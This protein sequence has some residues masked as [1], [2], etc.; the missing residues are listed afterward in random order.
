MAWRQFHPLVFIIVLL[1]PGRSFGWRLGSPLPVMLELRDRGDVR[2][3]WDWLLPSISRD[4]V[5]LTVRLRRDLDPRLEAAIE[6]T[7]ARF[8]RDEA[9]RTWHLGRVYGVIAPWDGVRALAAVAE[10]ERIELA[11]APGLV[12]HLDVSV[13]EIEA[14]RAW[15]LEDDLGTP[16]DGTGIIAADFDSGIDVF[17]PMFFHLDGGVYEW[18]DMGGDGRFD[19][20]DD[21]VDLDGDGRED[22]GE[23]LELLEGAL[24]QNGRGWVDGFYDADI[25][26]L[27]NDADLDGV[28]DYGPGAGYTDLDPSFGEMIFVIDD[29]DHDAQLDPGELLMGLGTSRII[30][31]LVA[32]DTIRYRGVDMVE[33]PVI[34]PG[35]PSYH[36]DH[37]TGVS[38]V[39]GGGWS[40]IGRRLTGVA[41]GVEL[42]VV[43]FNNE[44]GLAVTLPWVIS[45]GASVGAHP[46][47]HKVTSFLDGSSNDELAIDIAYEENDALQVISVGNEAANRD[48]ASAEVAGEGLTSLAFDVTHYEWTDQQVSMVILTLRWL[49]SEVPLSFAVIAPDGQRGEL[50]ATSGT[51]S[52]GGASI[53]HERADSPRGTAKF[54]IYIYV[55]SGSLSA[56]HWAIEVS[57]PDAEPVRVFATMMNDRFRGGMGSSF[58][59]ETQIDPFA[60]VSAYATA[61]RAIGACSYGTRYSYRDEV[62][63]QISGFSSR[64]PRI[65]GVRLVD[66]CA[67]GDN[68][69]IWAQAAHDDVP[70]GAYSFGGGTSASAPHV[71]GA[72]AL[73]QQAAPWATAAEIEDALE[74][75]ALADDFVGDEVPNH[76]WGYGKL[77]VMGALPLLP[78]PPSPD[79]DA[80][81]VDRAPW[82]SEITP[83]AGLPGLPPEPAPLVGVEGGGCHCGASG[84]PGDDAVRHAA[85]QLVRAFLR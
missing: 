32:P 69:I 43:D 66:V 9:G 56:G 59:D 30:A 61:D 79:R 60:T 82:E 64:G 5:G 68:D 23:Q 75:G 28:R 16:I 62:I 29:T 55:T 67:P 76:T 14:S 22:P 3:E 10:I 53:Q 19:P 4:E 83:D 11:R 44:L 40:G 25:D 57:N 50:G 84:D 34:I 1:V 20:G 8:R 46:Y 78:P 21:V 81:P 63:G 73:L 33:T 12:P 38:S 39:L 24:M 74:S 7:G 37:G 77:R 49:R 36:P 48:D 13:P 85:M 15:T 70:P 26:W 42:V 31:T 80:G 17:H 54:D 52:T 45:L 51:S 58:T 47:G 41:P 65:D 18:I 71:A 72:I 2:P 35:S 27:F 6:A